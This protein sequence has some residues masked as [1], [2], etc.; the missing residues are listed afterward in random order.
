M[1][2]DGKILLTVPVTNV[3]H[4]EGKEVVELFIGDKVSSEER[5]VKELRNFAKVSLV[6]GETKQV[7]FEITPEDL[8]Y[9]STKEHGFVAEP[10]IFKAYVCASET[11]VRGVAEFELK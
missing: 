8:Q 4:V 2:R 11:D 7:Q 9:W 5:P 10:G 6:P 1:S 3:G